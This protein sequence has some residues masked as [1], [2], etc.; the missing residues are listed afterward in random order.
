MRLAV[1]IVGLVVAAAVS[2]IVSVH[3]KPSYAASG[4]EVIKTRINFMKDELEHYWKPLAA[5]GKSGTGSLAEVEKNARAL[6]KVAEKIPSH[7]P[8]GTGRGNFPDKLTR[9]LPAIWTDWEG[10][11]KDVQDL[12]EGSEKL[13]RLAGEGNKDAVVEMIGTTGSYARTKIGCAECH[14]TFRGERVK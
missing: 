4:E 6:A 9:S 8:Q 10:F 7:F 1:K 13:A 5:Y 3:M 14:K 2:G 11:K 12:V